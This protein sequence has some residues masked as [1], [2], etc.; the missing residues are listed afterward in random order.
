MTMDDQEKLLDE[1]RLLVNR[2]DPVPQEVTAFADAALGW[3]RI[4]AELA[5]LLSDTALESEAAAA[6][7]RSGTRARAVTFRATGLEIDLEI[8]GADHGV[9][10]LGQLA[11]GS[12][13][14]I[15]VQRDDMTIATADADE[16]GRFRF[17]SME[18]GR[19]RLQILRENEPPVQTSWI[20]I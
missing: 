11:P 20:S 15:Q 2:V 14:S 18:T 7:V 5:D 8:R 10:V 6:A 13:A 12:R 19:V 3:R 1:L 9:T 4:D 16:H 17:E